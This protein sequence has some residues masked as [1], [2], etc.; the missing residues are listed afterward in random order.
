[1]LYG[2][3]RSLLTLIENIDQDH[4]TLFLLCPKKGPLT[5]CARQKG[6][7]VF[8]QPIKHW[9]SFGEDAKK[10]YK[11]RLLQFTK[12]LGQRVNNI[13]KLISDHNIDIVYTN[14]VTCIEGALAAKKNGRPHIWHLRE[15]VAGNKDLTPLIP[16][17]LISKI[18][19]WLSDQIIVNSQA[20]KSAYGF[21]DGDQKVSI[22]YNGVDPEAFQ[23]RP[24][25]RKLFLNEIEVPLDSKLIV[26]IASITPRKGLTTFIDAAA[27]LCQSFD[28]LIF[29]II[30]DGDEQLLKRLLDNVKHY[31]LEKKVLFLGWRTDINQ[32]LPCMD[33]MIVSAEQ[34]AFGRT[35]IEAMISGVPVL[36]T[37]CGG[38]EEIIIDGKTG[39]LVPVN[40]AAQL[41]TA[42]VKI[43]SNTKLAS[44]LASAGLIRAQNMFSQ[45]TYVRNVEV[46]LRQFKAPTLTKGPWPYAK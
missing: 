5:E 20:L 42:A 46:M 9:I 25:K 21:N 10:N 11:T 37:R 41:A 38:P 45:E 7:C 34:E 29:L 35:V 30:G 14:T 18:V 16:N 39:F 28:N 24:E 8:I 26:T 13:S 40:D 27:I 3:Q 19:R 33:L 32:I 22:I 15:H 44:S 1:M 17:R 4:F 6:I 31:R 12:S 23:L 2:A 36:S 43:L